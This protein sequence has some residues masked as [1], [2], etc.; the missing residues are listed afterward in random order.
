MFSLMISEIPRLDSFEVFNTNVIAAT[1]MGGNLV[2]GFVLLAIG[3]AWLRW[4][5]RR[6]KSNE[7]TN[8]API[9]AFVCG[10]LLASMYFM[11]DVLWFGHGAYT[12]PSDYLDTYWRVLVIGIV[13]GTLGSFAFWLESKFRRHHSD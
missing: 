5:H 3:V 8:S 10:P 4:L 7:R 6:S 2:A 13:A 11:A 1:R 12:I 9:I